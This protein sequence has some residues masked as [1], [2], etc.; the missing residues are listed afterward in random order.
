MSMP[1]TT[2]EASGGHSHR[3]VVVALSG[4][5][6]ALLLAQLDNLIVG[7][8]M[9]TI[10]GELGGLNHL[11]WVVTAYTLATATSTP[12]WGKLG[13]LYGRKSTLIIAIV[14]FL[15]GSALSGLSGS[16][17]QLIA[18]RA[19]QGLGGGGLIVGIMATIGDL[20]SPRERGR[21]QGYIAGVMAVSTIGGPLIGG[22]I[23]DNLGWRWNFYINLPVGVAALFVISA[24]LHLPAKQIKTKI[25]YLGAALLAVSVTSLVLIATWGGTEYDWGSGMILT[26]AA[27]AAVTAVAF[28]V[29]ELRAAEPLLPLGI[30]R[31]RNFSAVTFVGFFVGFLMFGGTVFIPLY[32]QTVQGASA[33]NS[34]LLLMPM[35]L[36]VLVI[37]LL[38]GQLITRTG[39]YKMFPIVGG[40]LLVF[41]M[42]LLSRLDMDT[43]R[44]TSGLFMVVTGA[45]IGFLMQTTML[46]AQNSVEV[47]DIGVATSTSMLFRTVGG[48]FGV[49]LFGSIFANRVQ[50]E[51]ASRLGGRAASLVSGSN[52]QMSPSQLDRLP[53]AA[54]DAYLHGVVS[55]VHSIFLW[56]ALLA[57]V[58][59]LASWVVKEVPLR[60]SNRP[61]AAGDAIVSG[62][63][64]E[65]EARSAVAA[66][67]S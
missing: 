4:L 46:I 27:V 49:A 23:T 53:A 31:N 8:A 21:Y 22:T 52:G 35:M 41:G 56:S 38:C 40:A 57:A 44:L 7:T 26:L 12:I 2:K 43:T 34:G 15:I 39:R 6:I 47:K 13:D 51:I 42:L 25:D 10:V 5:L 28:I 64:A 50:N 1:S 54:K 36:G 66:K 65:A 61:S 62:A 45:G 30:F 67:P 55:G 29:A 18:F 9:P 19:L 32:Q 60:K 14:I 3:T 37:G 20:V 59:F 33:T 17:G 11:S 24:T 58:A 63:G 48:S 16:M